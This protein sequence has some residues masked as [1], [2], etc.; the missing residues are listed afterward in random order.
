MLSADVRVVG[1]LLFPRCC[2]N[3]EEEWHVPENICEEICFVRELQ[4][5]YF[6]QPKISYQL[7]RM[8]I[9]KGHC[10]SLLHAEEHEL[11]SQTLPHR[12]VT[13]KQTDRFM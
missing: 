13:V 12:V 7:E 2:S 4:I 9:S 11:D 1:A 5:I 10:G 6:S 8:V 3:K